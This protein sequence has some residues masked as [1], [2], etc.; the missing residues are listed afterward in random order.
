MRFFV[1]TLKFLFFWFNYSV[2]CVA[3]FGILLSGEGDVVVS[4]LYS[5]IFTI[6]LLLVPIVL[7]IF[8]VKKINGN[9]VDINTAP[10]EDRE[11][12]ERNASRRKFLERER[13]FIEVE[14]HQ[15]ALRR[16]IS[17]SKRTNDYGAL[18]EDCSSAAIKEFLQSIS[19][20]TLA[21]TYTYGEKL[22]REHL[23]ELANQQEQVGFDATKI[24]VDGHEFE[25]W[26]AKSLCLYG[27][28]AQV[29][30]G[31][32]DQGIDVIATR[33]GF[34]LGIQCKLYSSSV[35]NKAIQEV[36]AGKAYHGVH[37]I[38]VLSNA[39]FTQSAKDLA[40]I[41]GVAL[42]SHHDIP[43]INRSIFENLNY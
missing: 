36:V 32:G 35:G 34:K 21:F 9:R 12:A 39:S 30:R 3:V 8:T 6:L 18:M 37:A 33:D 40:E 29:T 31:S 28:D 2:L 23:E 42:L 14:K 38:A 1:N 20:D 25:A 10:A 13:V 7:S 41:N 15:T 19:F 24:P 5:V 22:V 27:W 26:V 11:Q 17:R 43:H 16:N 4:P